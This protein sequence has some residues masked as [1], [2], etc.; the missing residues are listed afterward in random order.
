MDLAVEYGAWLPLGLPS[1]SKATYCKTQTEVRWHAQTGDQ[2]VMIHFVYWMYMVQSETL[3]RHRK[4]RLPPAFR[5]NGEGT[6]FTG[7]CPHFGGYPPSAILPNWGVLP[8]QVR[9]VGGGGVLPSKVRTGGCPQPEQ[10]SMYYSAGGMSL[11][12]TQ[13]DFLVFLTKYK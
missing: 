12:F 13:E 10:H 11:A 8:S 5:R 6:V 4:L 7:V 1:T 3:H 9:T 2:L